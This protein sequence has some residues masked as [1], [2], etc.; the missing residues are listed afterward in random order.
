MSAVSH[1]RYLPFHL[2][3]IFLVMDICYYIYSGIH[4]HFSQFTSWLNFSAKFLA[5]LKDNF[6]IL[7]N[8]LLKVTSATKLFFAIK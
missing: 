6:N 5:R 3:Q 1:P 8:S 4:G 7:Q 2:S